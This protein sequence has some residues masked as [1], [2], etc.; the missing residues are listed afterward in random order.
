MMSMESYF[1]LEEFN[2][3]SLSTG[4]AS[5]RRR[6]ALPPAALDIFDSAEY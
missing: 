4:Y 5:S 2:E 6:L 3:R 1:V